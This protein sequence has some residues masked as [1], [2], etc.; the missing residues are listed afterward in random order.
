VLS[1]ETVSDGFQTPGRK[2]KYH[3]LLDLNRRRVVSIF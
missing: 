1:I 3:F 2:R